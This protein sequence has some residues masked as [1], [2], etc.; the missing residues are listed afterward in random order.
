MN[1]KDK[2][3]NATMQELQANFDE[4]IDSHVYVNDGINQMEL[5]KYVLLQLLN[6][7]NYNLIVYPDKYSL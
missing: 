6:T 2:L 7:A 5:E 1:N 4:E 3:T